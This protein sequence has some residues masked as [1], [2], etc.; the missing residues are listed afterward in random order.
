M[1][2]A[3]ENLAQWG[4]IRTGQGRRQNP[5]EPGFSAGGESAKRWCETIPRRDFERRCVPRLFAA[6]GAN[7]RRFCGRSRS[8]GAPRSRRIEIK[9]PHLVE[10]RLIADAKHLGGVFAAPTRLFERVGNGFHFGFVFEAA[11][12]RFESLLARYGNFLARRGALTGRRHFDQ[13]AEAAFVVFEND[14][15]L[16]EIFEFAQVAGPRIIRCG[17]EQVL[18]WRHWSFAELLAVLVEEV[19][20]QQ[21]DFRGALAQWRNENRENVETVVEIF[22]EAAG[23]HG[24]LDGDVGGGE[25]GAG[26]FDHVASAKARI[27]VILQD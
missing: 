17:V 9:L 15:A 7:R 8:S 18:R 11:D 21:R 19:A 2:H 16:D 14:V 13:L 20:E 5:T 26:G 4:L 22:A 27:L 25:N 6:D 10:Q 1:L 24:F 12:E 3:I 23:L